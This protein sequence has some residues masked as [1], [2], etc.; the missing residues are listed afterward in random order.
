MLI[1]F[2]PLLDWEPWML[3]WAGMIA[4]VR[5]LSFAAGYVKFRAFAFLHTYANKVTGIALFCFPFIYRAAGL[6]ATAIILCCPASLSALEELTI[7]L[8]SKTLDR[9]TTGIIKWL[10]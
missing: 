6:T 4:V 8:R 1:I 10:K 7:N 9:N 3:W 2:I 5:V